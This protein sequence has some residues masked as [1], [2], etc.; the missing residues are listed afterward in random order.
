MA[1][2]TYNPIAVYPATGLQADFDAPD[3]FY[4]LDD[5]RAVIIIDGV[6]TLVT[7]GVEYQVIVIGREATPPFRQTGFLRF[8]IP[9][10]SGTKVVPFILPATVQD[11]PF[12]GRA[13]TPR[14]HER[15]HDRHTQSIAMLFEF[16]NR[17]YRSP[18]DTPPALRFIAAG[19]EG[20][21][22]QWDASGSL[23]EGPAVQDLLDAVADVAGALEAAAAAQLALAQISALLAGVDLAS[24]IATETDAFTFVQATHSG[25]TVRANFAAEEL[26]T[27]PTNAKV[28]DGFS[29]IQVGFGQARFV[30][31]AGATLHHI[32]GNSRTLAQWGVV[33]LIVESNVGGNAASWV[34][35][36]AT[37]E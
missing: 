21:V 14:Q 32:I 15:V 23:I 26:V 11:Q 35:F 3:L 29:V 10:A 36:G 33:S 7:R 31:A 5:V 28:N 9:P 34:L 4:D 8:A 25:R 22:P 13:V 1:F 12:E 37:A 6:E 19:R 18:L 24:G 16:F 20:Y 2:S 17:G 30:P 27:L